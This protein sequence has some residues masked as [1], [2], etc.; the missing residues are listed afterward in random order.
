MPVDPPQGGMYLWV[1]IPTQ[2]S[3]HGFA[4]RILTEAA[5]VVTPGSAYG[6]A[7]EGFVRMALTLPEDRLDEA[8]G[9][10]GAVL[11]AT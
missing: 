5:V 4:E 8:I 3:A 7:G 9:R 11:A 6:S 2:E 1:P 10:I